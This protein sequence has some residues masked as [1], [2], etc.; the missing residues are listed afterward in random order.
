MDQSSLAPKHNPTIFFEV[1]KTWSNAPRSL[2]EETVAQLLETLQSTA[3]TPLRTR[4]WAI[5]ELLYDCMLRPCEACGLD[6]SN[7][8]FESRKILVLGKGGKERVID[9]IPAASYAL[10]SYL[11]HS[12]PVLLRMSTTRSFFVSVR[13]RRLSRQHIWGIVSAALPEA[14]PYKLRHSGAKHLSDHGASL[15]DIQ[16]GLGHKDPSTTAIYTEGVSTENLAEAHRRF[17]PRA[18]KHG[19][20]DSRPNRRG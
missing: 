2:S 10:S 9:L 5:V 1:K 8:D 7:V 4:D 13:G 3:I 19:R 11:L 6:L 18:K 12:R 17:H 15:E 16:E 20:P 14:Y